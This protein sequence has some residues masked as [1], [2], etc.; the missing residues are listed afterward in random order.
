[1]SWNTKALDPI[2]EE[3]GYKYIDRNVLNGDAESNYRT[4]EELVNRLKETI[5][6]FSRK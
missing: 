5:N 6:D 4:V 2:L 1:M 3:N